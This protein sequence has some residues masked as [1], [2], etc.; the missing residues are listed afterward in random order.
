MDAWTLSIKG[1]HLGANCMDYEHST[2]QKKKKKNLRAIPQSWEGL[3]LLGSWT[4]GQI[5]D[6]VQ[7]RKAKPTAP[8]NQHLQG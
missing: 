3:Q 6:T 2:H 8:V 7:S 5:Q 4:A 1:T